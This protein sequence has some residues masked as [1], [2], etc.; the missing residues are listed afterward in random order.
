MVS[1][2]CPAV[3]PRAMPQKMHCAGGPTYSAAP[4]EQ[5]SSSLPAAHPLPQRPAPVPGWA[6]TR[7]HDA[8]AE[9][10]HPPRDR[11]LQSHV[12]WAE[13]LQLQMLS[14]S[15]SNSVLPAPGWQR[16]PQQG[17][18][19]ETSMLGSHFSAESCKLKHLWVQVFCPRCLQAPPPVGSQV[20]IC[21]LKVNWLESKLCV[22]KEDRK[23]IESQLQQWEWGR[24][25]RG[26][27]ARHLVFFKWSKIQTLFSPRQSK[28][29]LVAK[30]EL[31]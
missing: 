17:H 18:R 23:K 2:P 20:L 12:Y 14:L 24:R 10:S 8:G 30:A 22:V 3:P 25:Q 16:H 15:K 19:Q 9:G 26:L 27:W 11:E 21:T 28:D 5:P 4:L 31:S 13:E 6:V 1:A 7:P 29:K